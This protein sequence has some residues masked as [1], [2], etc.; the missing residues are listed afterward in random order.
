MRRAAK[1]DA[2]QL[3]AVEDL[4][5]MGYSVAITSAVG[6]DFPDCVVGKS[7]TDALV[8]FKT[9]PYLTGRGGAISRVT[10]HDLISPGQ[11]EFAA[12]W[13]GSAVIFAYDAVMVDNEFTRR[14]EARLRTYRA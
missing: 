2:T 10:I 5:R 4:R 6:K 14:L 9:P 1:I 7:G 13:K 8:E 12:N 3:Q 11:R